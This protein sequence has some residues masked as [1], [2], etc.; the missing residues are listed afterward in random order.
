MKNFIESKDPLLSIVTV[1]MNGERYLE[2]TIKSVINQEYNNF[3]YIIIDGGSTDN[4][5]NIIK[6][7]QRHIDK[8]ISEPDKGQTDALIKGFSQCSGDILYWLNYD[9]LLHDVKTLELV[10]G[11]FKENNN[12]DLVYGDDLL[13]DKDLNVIKLRDFSYHTL[14][15]LLYYKSI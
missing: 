3:E 14:G 11:V 9:D 15:K 1:V 13:V 10:A 8:W 4:T 5:I 12:I 7:Y 6:K 2:E